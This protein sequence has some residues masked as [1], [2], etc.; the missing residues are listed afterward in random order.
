VRF[1]GRFA[2]DDLG[3]ELLTDLRS[4]GVEVVPA[5][6]LAGSVSSVVVAVVDS[7]GERTLLSA[8]RRSAQTQL[9]VDDLTEAIWEGVAWVHASGI[10]LAADP[11][12]SATLGMLAR[13][14]RRGL[15]RSLDVNLRLEA[16][17]LDGHVR[18]AVGSAAEL[19]TVVF[20]SAT[21][22]LT[23]AA[24]THDIEAAAGALAGGRRTAVVR[25]GS[26]GA[27][28]VDPGGRIWR[29]VG[30]PGPVVDSLG[31]GDTFDAGYIRAA[32]D[33]GGV[34]TCL[35]WA[36]AAAALK[37]RHRGGRG[38][39]GIDALLELLGPG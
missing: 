36:N 7:A 26:Q 27:I 21:E 2:D 38:F 22:A 39:P 37:I 15:P 13:A 30:M 17:D 12:R 34:D 6:L 11:G 28:A 18:D 25:L 31:A 29:H 24:G 14:A 9:T 20:A 32:L 35:P 5:Q 19:S 23:L 16:D 8:G 1:L 3:V 4:E 33:G 10:S